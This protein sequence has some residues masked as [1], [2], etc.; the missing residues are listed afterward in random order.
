[1]RV[2]KIEGGH[3]LSGTIEV[4]GAKNSVVA[5][6]SAAIL[7]HGK[8]VIEDVPELSDVFVLMTM[9]ERLHAVV[10]YDNHILEIDTTELAFEPLL[11]EEV[12]KLRASYY[13]MGAM[14]GRFGKAV[15]GI[16]GGCYLGPRPMDLHLKGFHAL[17]ID[18]EHENGAY[19]LTAANGIVGSRINLD[20][21]SVGATINIIFAAVYAKGT[22][23][24]ESA[25]K[26]P[27]IIDVT[28]LL[29]SMGA[30]ITGA[31]TDVIRIE[32]V[33]R[34]EGCR[35]QIIPDRIVAGSY[36]LAG[37]LIG[38]KLRI[39]NVIVEHMEAVLAKI[40]EA[41][42]E[43]EIGEDYIVVSKIKNA[44]TAVTI[45]T[46]TY[47]GFPTDLQQPF[48]VLMTQ[49]AGMSLVHESIYNA[50]FKHIEELS[51]MGATV[52]QE[53]AT[54]IV[55]GPTDLQATR[56]EATDLRAGMAM[57][58]AGLIADGVTEVKYIEHV[59]RGYEQ[60]VDKL[61]AVGAK[62]WIEEI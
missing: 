54:A 14:I 31:G 36:L 23:Y 49:L 50:R 28:T 55:N 38:D 58:L 35:H 1:M 26:E 59:E 6:I 19:N 33:N 21:A 51:R 40:Q 60:I 39:N 47:P 57:I 22:T 27:E 15:V 34:L 62:I 44:G 3:T 17:G 56:V 11:D 61:T 30:K 52:R 29:N 2:F 42:A 24:I 43:L 32:G 48:T 18:V 13:L 25:A 41:G 5:L 16:P 4:S 7:S 20:I 46:M 53:N 9:L 8:V 37:A 45:K 12:Q 10:K